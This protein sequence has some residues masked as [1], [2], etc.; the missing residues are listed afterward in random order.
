[1]LA[2]RL[3]VPVFP[4][5]RTEGGV[6]AL[7]GQGR[8]FR[9]GRSGWWY[10]G[11]TPEEGLARLV[12]GYAPALVD[13]RGQWAEPAPLPRAVHEGAWTDTGPASE[14]L[15]A[16]LALAASATR[17]LRRHGLPALGGLVLTVDGE[18]A[19]FPLLHKEFDLD[20]GDPER[21]IAEIVDRT[22]LRPGM[23]P[24]KVTVRLT[25]SRGAGEGGWDVLVVAHADRSRQLSLRHRTPAGAQL[26]DSA[27]VTA[28]VTALAALGAAH[29]TV[30]GTA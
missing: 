6:L 10:L 7:D 17:P 25:D 14:L 27:D 13:G 15:A 20:A 9:Q 5:G 19:E 18:G 24:V 26:P 28:T 2:D 23:R 16:A 1:M 30:G 22:F 29:R 21:A 4:V 3:G 11:A 8:L 12:E